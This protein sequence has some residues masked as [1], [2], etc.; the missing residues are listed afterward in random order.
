MKGDSRGLKN[1][2]LAYNLSTKSEKSIVYPES[3]LKNQKTFYSPFLIS[4]TPD[5]HVS[6][7]NSLI[8]NSIKLSARQPH[9]VT[10]TKKDESHLFRYVLELEE[11]RIY[12]LVRI[13]LME[14]SEILFT[15][16]K[17]FV[18]DCGFKAVIDNDTSQ[19][20]RKK[21]C[22]TWSHYKMWRF[23]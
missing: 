5:Y 18:P 17:V 15:A 1:H 23:L 9:N 13:W 19:L 20:H 6:I 14:K 12:F 21:R 2:I 4:F 22:M 7:T 16:E 3:H 11:E 10:H 8:I